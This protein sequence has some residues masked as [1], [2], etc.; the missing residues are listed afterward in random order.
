MRR[1]FDVFGDI[2]AT[3][4]LSVN[5][6]LH[7]TG[8]ILKLFYSEISYF[9]LDSSAHIHILAQT[10]EPLLPCF[11]LPAPP[12]AHSPL[13]A[14][15]C[16]CNAAYAEGARRGFGSQKEALSALSGCR[17][18][19]R[20]VLT[21]FYRFAVLHCEGLRSPFCVPPKL[22]SGA[23]SRFLSCTSHLRSQ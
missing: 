3:S 22:H 21:V 5:L 8:C 14:P 4:H 15:Q 12:T 9:S 17:S 6:N 2:D 11:V 23:A 16:I 13:H 18:N 10:S 20:L 7:V 19:E 1:A